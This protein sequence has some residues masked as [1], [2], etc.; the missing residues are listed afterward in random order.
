MEM[1]INYDFLSRRTVLSYITEFPEVTFLCVLCARCIQVEMNALRVDR[2]R[3]SFCLP[4]YFI[5]KITV[6]ISM[7]FRTRGLHYTAL[8]EFSFGSYRSDTVP[9]LRECGAKLP[10]LHKPS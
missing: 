10:L 9:N 2:F 6:R 4:K 7:M 5:S 8:R 3:P 1:Y